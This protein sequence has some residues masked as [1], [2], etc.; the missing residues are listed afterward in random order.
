[1]NADHL[2][3]KKKRR[4][5]KFDSTGWLGAGILL[6]VALLVINLWAII[7]QWHAPFFPFQI[8]KFL[9]VGWGMIMTIHCI[10]MIFYYRK[11]GRLK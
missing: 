8:G 5:T 6:S 11:H 9:G 2:E 7:A 4:L 10:D 3:I 1:M